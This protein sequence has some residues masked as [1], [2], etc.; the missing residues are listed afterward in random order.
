MATLNTVDVPLDTFSLHFLRDPENK[1]RLIYGRGTSKQQWLA[2]KGLEQLNPLDIETYFPKNSRV[3]ILAPHPDDEIL[4]CA[5]LMQK[6]SRLQRNIVL[7]AI[8]NGTGS[9]PD[10]PLYTQDQLN[11]IRP[12]ESKAALEVLNIQNIQRIAFNL[13]DG[14]IATSHAQFY[15]QLEQLIQANDILITTYEKDGHP[16]HEHSAY[17]VSKTAKKY[18]L[19]YF[20]VLI[21]TWH[22]AQP[23]NAQIAWT[24]AYRLD[25]SSNE[26]ELKHRAIQC[27]KSQLEI[28]SSTGQAPILSGEVVD[29]ILMPYEV[30]IHGQ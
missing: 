5:G 25:L 9:H 20:Q 27:F 3:L 29:R 24:H 12:A 16:D 28:D 21:W 4:G 1:Q 8:T 13:Q 26:L 15:E 10:S 19:K 22:W 2:W 30:Y 11:Q 6:L 23:N 18:Q 14:A 7:V 17:V